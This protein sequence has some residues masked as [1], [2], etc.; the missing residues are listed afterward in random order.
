MKKGIRDVDDAEYLG[1][2]ALCGFKVGFCF[3]TNSTIECQ[4]TEYD[5]HTR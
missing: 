5:F 2:K 3:H 1:G 4:M